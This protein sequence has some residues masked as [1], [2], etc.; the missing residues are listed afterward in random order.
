GHFSPIAG[1]SETDDMV[2]VLEVRGDRELFWVSPREL[3]SAIETVDPVCG[4]NR[5]WIVV[6][7]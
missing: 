1:F 5:G 2:L 6:S 7:R 3:Y 4:L